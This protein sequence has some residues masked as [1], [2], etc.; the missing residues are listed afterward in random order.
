[1]TQGYADEPRASLPAGA[2]CA[3]HPERD[4]QATCVRC[5]NYMCSECVG[6]GAPAGRGLCLAC[7]SRDGVTGTFPFNRDN[8]TLDGLLNLSLSRWKPHLLGLAL[9]VVGFFLLVYVPALLFTL[10]FGEGLSLE[11]FRHPQ[12]MTP[13]F[14]PLQMLIRALEQL[15]MVLAQ[16][17]AYLVLFGYVLDI[18]EGKPVSSA[19]ALQRLRAFPAQ[20][21]AMLLMYGGIALCVAL[22]A[23]AFWL[24][25][26]VA[27]LPRSL[28]VGALVAMVMVS[29]TA[30]VTIGLSFVTLELAHVPGLSALAAMR[31]SWQLVEGRRWRIGGVMFVAGLVGFVGVL[32]CCV[33][34]L[35]SFPIGA[36]LHASLF[37]ALKQEPPGVAALAVS[38][39]FPV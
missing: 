39:E 29:V 22:V 19:R 30:Y 7:A 16:L 34:L 35:A 33:G 23:L 15:A 5:G 1:M 3:H 6:S 27:G 10:L 24:A 25:G 17:A 36:L 8:Y 28:G 12:Q 14:S 4:A 21:G 31:A 26:G 9:A 11:A 13:D 37:L 18:L 2:R 32:A 38:R 20:V